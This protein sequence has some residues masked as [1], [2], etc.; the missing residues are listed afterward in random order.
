MAS[1]QPGIHV[2]DGDRDAEH[3]DVPLIGQN[4]LSEKSANRNYN[5]RNQL[6]LTCSAV[7][8]FSSLLLF[9]TSAVLLLRSANKHTSKQAAFEVTQTYSPILDEIDL[10]ITDTR[11]NGSLWPG[12][13]PNAWRGF[14][15]HATNEAWA[16]FEKGSPIVLSSEQ[17]RR[18]G[19][20]PEIAAK[21]EDEYWGFG[22]DAYIGELDF[23]HQV[24]W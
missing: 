22:P 20:D 7:L 15:D 14:P 17:I 18:I 11:L 21:Y 8:F 13:S 3:E 16:T 10:T 4:E 24:H 6:V 9:G 12:D 1:S 2:A 5:R 19:K 23:V